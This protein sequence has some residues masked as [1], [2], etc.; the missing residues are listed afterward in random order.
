MWFEENPDQIKL[1]WGRDRFLTALK[2]KESLM[3]HFIGPPIRGEGERGQ[4]YCIASPLPHSGPSH[5]MDKKALMG[6]EY[7]YKSNLRQ[8]T[9]SI[10]DIRDRDKNAIWSPDLSCWPSRHPIYRAWPPLP[11][12][13]QMDESQN[14]WD[15]IRPETI[16]GTWSLILFS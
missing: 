7:L 4:I 9:P 11:R 12:V 6:P 5:L 2:S 15:Q 1:V 16:Y 10:V 8:K 13:S 3:T 14:I